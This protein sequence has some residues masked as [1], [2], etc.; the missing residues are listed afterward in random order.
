MA[1]HFLW[2][3]GSGLRKRAKRPGKDLL[4]QAMLPHLRRAKAQ[5]K[6]K[7]V[8]AMASSVANCPSRCSLGVPLRRPKSTVKPQGPNCLRSR[9][10]NQACSKG[11]VHTSMACWL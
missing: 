4:C 11:W 10:I 1:K 3:V 6:W 7:A 9:N 5:T 8:V 2:M